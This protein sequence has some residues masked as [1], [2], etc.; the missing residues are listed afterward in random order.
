M[1]AFGMKQ[2]PSEGLKWSALLSVRFPPYSVE[3][4]G[5]DIGN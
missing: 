3:K 2:K 1:S 4:A 5:V